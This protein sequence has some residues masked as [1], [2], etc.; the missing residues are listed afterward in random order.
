MTQ[1]LVDNEMWFEQDECSWNAEFM[2][3]ERRRIAVLC[4]LWLLRILQV[5]CWYCMGAD[6][7]MDNDSD[8]VVDSGIGIHITWYD[9]T[10]KGIYSCIGNNVKITKRD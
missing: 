1:R 7:D 4:R 10:W 9:M 6:I 2:H 3:F 8:I 5:A